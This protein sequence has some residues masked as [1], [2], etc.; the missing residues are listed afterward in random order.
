MWHELIWDLQEYKTRL[1][2]FPLVM[3]QS[4]FDQTTCLIAN[5]RA[6]RTH[7]FLFRLESVQIEIA[8]D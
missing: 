5:S 3:N 1:M 4:I 6:V 7:D 8:Q 2:S